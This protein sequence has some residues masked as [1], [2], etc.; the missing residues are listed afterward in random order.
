MKTPPVPLR[1]LAALC[2]ACVLPALAAAKPNIVFIMADDLGYTDVGAFGS[3]YYET[4]NIDRL[5]QQGTRLTNYHQCQNCQPTRAALMTGQYSPRTGVYTVGGIER[6]DWSKRPLRPVDNVSNLPLDR[7]I[8]PQALKSAGYAT[9]MFG[10]WHLGQTGE[11]HPGK[12]GFDEAVVSMGQHFD[13]VTQ[14]PV[15]Y[16]KGQ[17][18]ADFLTDK[19]VDFIKRHKDGPFFLYLPHF[20]VHSPHQAKPELIAKFKQKA[21]VG[22]HDNPAYA[23]MIASVD[24]SVGRV[25]ATLDEL[26]LAE[27]TVLVF[28]S[29]NG[30][31]GGYERE[32]IKGEGGDVTDNAPLRSGKGSLYEGGTRVPF[33]VRWPGQTKAGTANDVPAIHVDIYPTLVAIAGGKMPTSQVFDGESLVPLFRNPAGKLTRD[34]IYQH[35]PGYLGA[36]TNWRTTP[37]SYIHAGDWKLME[38]LEDRHLELYNLRDDIGEKNNLAAA[39]PERAKEMYARLVAWRTAIKAP[40]PTPNTVTADAGSTKKKKAG[41]GKKKK[42]AVE[43]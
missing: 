15:S 27:N 28:V 30:G 11:Y 29:D 39:Q 14:P 19:A 8:L 22:G 5:A 40:M 32:G 3:K 33:I 6:F 18:L 13:F 36:G 1:A 24:E 2:I 4:P 20:G 21:P 42:A 31:V 37:V 17:Y 23:A 16:P 25:M 26:K 34:A 10:K 9:G 43:P 41:G 7:T 35:F 12:R 38:Y